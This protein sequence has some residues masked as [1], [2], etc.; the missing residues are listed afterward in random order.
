MKYLLYLPLFPLLLLRRLRR[1]DQQQH[2]RNRHR[3]LYWTGSDLGKRSRSPKILRSV[4]PTS[5]AW[6]DWPGPRG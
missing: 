1:S 2:L 3:M 4:N 5:P 6:K